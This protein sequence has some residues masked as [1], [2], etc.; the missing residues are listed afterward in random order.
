MSQINQKKQAY[1][2]AQKLGEKIEV[3]SSTVG[4]QEHFIPTVQK[5]RDE[6]QA[7]IND[8]QSDE[9]TTDLNRGFLQAYDFVLNY[10]E[11]KMKQAKTLM[12]KNTSAKL[13]GD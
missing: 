11:E 6:A 2:L 13:S 10:A 9:R 12:R 8:P 5:K 7:I 1:D 4:W 3:M